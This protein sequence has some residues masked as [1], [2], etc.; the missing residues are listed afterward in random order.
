MDDG[1]TV[2]NCGCSGI[3]LMLLSRPSAWTTC[4]RLPCRSRTISH[5]IR[6]K[7]ETLQSGWLQAPFDFSFSSVP[8]LW[9]NSGTRRSYVVQLTPPPLFLSFTPSPPLFLSLSPF[10]AA[11]SM[12]LI[13]SISQSLSVIARLSVPDFSLLIH[14]SV[15]SVTSNPWSL[16]S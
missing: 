5:S 14:P 16:L 12:S 9:K 13:H 4:E 11:L 1:V 2:S 6:K 15:S 10:T 3:R 8:A 7:E